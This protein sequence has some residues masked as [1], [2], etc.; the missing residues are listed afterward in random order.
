MG[1]FG[2]SFEN[3]NAQV[4]KSVPDCDAFHFKNPR[5]LQ[6]FTRRIIPSKDLTFVIVYFTSRAASVEIKFSFKFSSC[7][8]IGSSQKKSIIS[9]LGMVYLLDLWDDS[10]A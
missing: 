7:I 1:N 3:W 5:Y 9:E 2:G 4:G 8:K 10:D 6:H